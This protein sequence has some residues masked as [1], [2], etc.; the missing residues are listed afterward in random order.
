MDLVMVSGRRRLAF[1]IKAATAPTLTKGFY[2]ARED[3]GAER[4]F[5]IS[6]VDESWET[7]DGIVQTR[8][9]DLPECLAEFMNP[10]PIPTADFQE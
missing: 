7:S 8:M 5:V 9:A 4:I 10:R 2:H 1:E 6:R 3:I